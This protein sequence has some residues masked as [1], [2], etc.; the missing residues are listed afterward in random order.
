MAD[1]LTHLFVDVA[2]GSAT[3]D[4]IGDYKRK[5]AHR[6]GRTVKVAAAEFDLVRAEAHNA[7]DIALDDLADKVEYTKRRQEVLNG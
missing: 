1:V 3:Q 5:V 2:I 7:L 4:E 6:E